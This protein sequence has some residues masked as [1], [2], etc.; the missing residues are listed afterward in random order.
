MA[1]FKH[2]LG[3]RHRDLLNMIGRNKGRFF[4]AGLCMLLISG[5]TAA[6]GYLLKPVIDDIFVNKDVHGLVL[7]PLLVIAVFMVKSL[8]T[9]GQEYFMSY[10][11]QDVIRNLRDKLYDHIQDL[12]L[13]FF[14]GERTGVLMSRIM[15]DVGV[16]RNMVSD[17]VAGAVRDV[18]TILGLAGVILYMNWRLAIIAFVVLPVAYFPVARLGK[19]VRRVST[20]CQVAMGDMSAFLHETI[21]GNKIVK[22]FGME[23]HE[24]TRFHEKNNALFRMEIRNVIIRTLSSPLME[25]FGGLAIA[26]VIW[27]GGWEVIRGVSTPGT[28]MSF[29]T[30]TM[31]LYDPIRKLG[32]LN[33]TI[34]MG[35]SATDRIYE[36]I[37]TRPTIHD[38][39]HPRPIQNHPHL[40]EFD[41][42]SFSYGETAVLKGVSLSVKQGQV[43]ALVGMS[44]GGKSTLVNL[45]PR[46]Y[47]VTGGR[48]R[49]DGTDIREFTIAD[50]RSQIAVVTQEPILFNETVRDNIAYGRPGATDDEIIAAAKAAYAHE[51][52][53]RFPNGYDTL[54]GELG[55]R[56]SGGEK[57]RLCIAR[58]L[59]K[60]APILILDEAT[61]ALD[62]E[63][64][65]LV[66]KALENLMA[67]RTTVV[68]AHRLSTI[69]G[70]DQIAVIVDGQVAERG[71]H[72]E[73]LSKNGEYGKL[74]R[75]QHSVEEETADQHGILSPAS[76]P[77]P[78]FQRAERAGVRGE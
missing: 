1:F 58:A 40:L 75:M 78:C 54:I 4:L 69:A 76:P 72:A 73:L 32:K 56:L 65:S 6:M 63:A 15:N 51:F 19:K 71:T 35:L 29:L 24:K 52:I 13:S 7:F 27:Y 61:A 45:I 26:F 9:Y 68:I 21:S 34:Q 25:F 47:D 10:I 59:I 28:F 49:I 16:L 11:A 43:L 5:S 41:D 3:Y 44:G 39:Q 62:T 67:G 66:Q 77:S 8:G 57:Q 20:N 64:E 36:I 74:Y 70:A 38:P 42:V 14:L 2:K 37:E 22:A 18:F 17:S 33:N 31:L 30:C 50:L 12:P 23:S 60:N 46:F 53:L 48:I 55:S